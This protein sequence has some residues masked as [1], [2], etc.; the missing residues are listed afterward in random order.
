MASL[1]DGISL[2]KGRKAQ[3]A[4]MAKPCLRTCLWFYRGSGHSVRGVGMGTWVANLR[5]LPAALLPG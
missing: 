3:K 2:E 5:W 4:D 1:L